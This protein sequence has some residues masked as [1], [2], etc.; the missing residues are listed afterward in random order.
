MGACF[1]VAGA[2]VCAFAP[3]VRL[4]GGIW[5]GVGLLLL[6]IGQKA[7]AGAAHRRQ[8]L[9][10]GKAGEATILEVADTGV[11]INNS[12]RVRIKVRIE[13]PGEA[14]IEASTAMMV[15]RVNVPRPGE[16]YTVRFDPKNPNDFAFAPA[17]SSGHRDYASR[18]SSAAPGGSD[19]IGQLERLAA[20][21]DKGAL[22]P[23]E[24]EAQKRKL[25]GEA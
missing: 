20:L 8:L 16:V 23:A 25:L 11:T 15:S 22:T 17:S 24:F 6:V 14:P 3:V 19:T 21:R 9:Q 5:I 12:P 4:M 7:A 10:T 1:L 13:V 18:T 2:A